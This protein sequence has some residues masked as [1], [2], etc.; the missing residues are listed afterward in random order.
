MRKW[1][2][3]FCINLLNNVHNN[4]IKVYWEIKMYAAEIGQ[5]CSAMEDKHVELSCCP[6]GTLLS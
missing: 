5:N 1:G 4:Y 3:N 6:V 2:Y